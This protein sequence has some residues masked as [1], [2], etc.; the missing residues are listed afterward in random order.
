MGPPCAL[1]AFPG[2]VGGLAGR[3]RD[4]CPF[5]TLD[6]LWG[7]RQELPA[8]EQARKQAL[9][10][11]HTRPCCGLAAFRAGRSEGVQAPRV[12]VSYGSLGGLRL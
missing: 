3:G 6:R 7:T 2:G 8:R 12:R 5:L 9:T 11:R 10:G 1:G 4:G